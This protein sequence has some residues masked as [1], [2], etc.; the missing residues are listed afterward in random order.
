MVHR[1]CTRIT[2][3]TTPLGQCFRS[4][5]YLLQTRS[6]FGFSRKPARQ[7]KDADLAP[8]IAKMSELDHASSLNTRPPDAGELVEAFQELFDAKIAAKEPL[9]DFEALNAL[10]TLLHL[11]HLPVVDGK[12]WLGW[13]YVRMGLLIPTRTPGHTDEMHKVQAHKRLA[14][15]LYEVLVGRKQVDR[16]AGQGDEVKDLQLL[17]SVLVRLGDIAEA[18]KLVY[19]KVWKKG[20]WKHPEETWLWQKF[21]IGH[22]NNDNKEGVLRML[23]KSNEPGAPVLKIPYSGL[24]KFYTRNGDLE[25]AK[26]WYNKF[27]SRG[28]RVLHWTTYEGLLES[29]IKYGDLEWGH[30]VSRSL[31]QEGVPKRAWDIIFVWAAFTGRGVEEIDR[32]MNVMMERSQEHRP[33]IDTINRLVEWAV[34]KN[35]PYLVERYIGL[36][37]KRKITPN[38]NTF[39]LQMESRLS[40]GDIEGAGA[41]Y[42]AL[43]GESVSG[44]EDLPAINRYIRAMCASG[45]YGFEKIMRVASDLSERKVRF[46]PDTVAA[47]CLLHLRR[48]ELHDVIDLLQT[49]AYRFSFNQRAKIRD[50]FVEYCLD[51]GNTVAQAW[52]AYTIF[53]HI[54]S[55]SGRDVKTTIMRDFFA[56]RRSDMAVHVFNHMRHSSNPDARA[57]SD[58]YVACFEGI[59]RAADLESL[60]TVHNLLKLD[61]EIE[62]STRL[63]NSLMLAYTACE[64]PRQALEYWDEIVN[65]VEGPSYNSIQLAFQACEDVPWGDVNAKNIWA[66]LKNLKIEMSREILCTYVGA[67]AGNGLLADA[68]KIIESAEAK[69][70]IKPDLLM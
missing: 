63:Y 16:P 60:E 18:E 29:C 59:G 34:S 1:G 40:V 43:R 27:I 39:V 21:L 70:G 58:T 2:A 38:A 66:L 61:L 3:K 6:L 49:H 48:E 17:V 44:T 26:H 12:P 35:D 15:A 31:T 24:I 68:V 64:L 51:H 41:T 42:E 47:L 32:M 57:N 20:S 36:A 50:T 62:F 37:E 9:E 33:D 65:S 10:R 7:V 14:Y 45:R 53:H 28:N 54:I 52:D 13:S 67:L 22:C 56:R 19:E 11:E 46:E 5:T 55:E 30:A 69:M 8:G 25:G 23:A 4:S